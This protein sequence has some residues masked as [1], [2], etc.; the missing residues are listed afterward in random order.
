MDQS[1]F[2]VKPGFLEKADEILEYLLSKVR[3]RTENRRVVSMSE[4]G[5]RKFYFNISKKYPEG[6]ADMARAFSG[7]PITLTTLVGDNVIVPVR[8][9]VGPMRYEDNSNETIRGM[10]GPYELPNTIVHASSS[11][12]DF[13]RELAILNDYCAEK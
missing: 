2:F 3:C 6:W 13:K 10:W 4:E 9:I 7:R 1:I 11:R 12:E 5:W 8:K